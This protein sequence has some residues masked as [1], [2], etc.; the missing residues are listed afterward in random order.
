MSAF[1]MYKRKPRMDGATGAAILADLVAAR[2]HRDALVAAVTK[3][4]KDHGIWSPY[5]RCSDHAEHFGACLD[6]L[7]DEMLDQDKLREAGEVAT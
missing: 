3:L 6:N 2:A 4:G 7:I 5:L 1:P